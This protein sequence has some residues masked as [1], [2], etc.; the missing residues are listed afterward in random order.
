[1]RPNF[2]PPFYAILPYSPTELSFR[3]HGTWKTQLISR[4]ALIIQA[5]ATPVAILSCY[6]LHQ[7]RLLS[8]SPTKIFCCSV[9]F[10][11]FLVALLHFT[12]STFSK[13]SIWSAFQAQALVVPCHPNSCC[14]CNALFFVLS[15]RTVPVSP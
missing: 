9:L 7:L 14:S 10:K 5:G 1:M 3:M 11:T 15:P 8:E 6:R 12:Q 2:I 4:I 13:Q